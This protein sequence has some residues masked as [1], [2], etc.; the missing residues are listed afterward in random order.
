MV[1]LFHVTE[2]KKISCPHFFLN[3]SPIHSSERA[4]TIVAIDKAAFV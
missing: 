4:Q 3:L 2:L 1:F